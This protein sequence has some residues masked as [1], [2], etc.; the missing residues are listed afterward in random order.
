MKL[1]NNLE[2]ENYFN[3]EIIKELEGKYKLTHPFDLS[4]EDLLDIKEL[5]M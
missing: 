1:T 5:F 2:I 3:E 4:N